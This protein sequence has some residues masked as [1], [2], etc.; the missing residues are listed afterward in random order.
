MARILGVDYGTRRLGFAVSDPS[1]II[2]TPLR[3]VGV[4]N[5][6]DAVRATVA[7]SEEKESEAIVVGMPY[8]MDGTIGPAAEAVIAFVDKVRALVDI[9]VETWDERLTTSMIERVLL[10][11]DASRA[12]RKEVRDKLAAQ[13][14]LQGYLDRNAE[15]AMQGI[16]GLDL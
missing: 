5:P 16:D 12:R 6:A 9:P 15:L 10:Q 8:N 2:G 3:V 4:S 11:A 14:I 1:G 7:V 13:V